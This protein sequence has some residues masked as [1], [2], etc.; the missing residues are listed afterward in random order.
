MR[1]L[2]VV[3]LVVTWSA[4]SAAELP[5]P[6]AFVAM[7]VPERVALWPTWSR[8]EQARML[9]SLSALQLATISRA[10]LATLGSYE[11]ELTKQERVNGKILPAQVM[12]VG[13][14]EKPFAARLEV[15][16]GPAKGRR[17]VYNSQN[18]PG[19]LRVREA[20]ILGYTG[21]HWLD[22]NGS[23][24]RDDTAH[25]ITDLGFGNALR[26]IFSDIAAA[27]AAGG[28]V[29]H[30]E[31]FDADGNYCLRTEAPPAARTYA[32][33]SRLCFEP[34]RGLP[35]FAED[36]DAKGFMERLSWKNVRSRKFT[37]ADFMP[38]AMGL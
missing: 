24:A 20:G 4:A 30:D 35:V 5:R 34:L 6:E 2:L 9:A 14:R 1:A 32:L 31:G 17:V 37:D 29:R 36:H 21:A 13:I 22:I 38:E 7:S 28:M 11:G 18:R 3:L 8:D 33:K 15:I 26:I 16:A 25:P 12:R 10:A 23:L 19:E 27:E